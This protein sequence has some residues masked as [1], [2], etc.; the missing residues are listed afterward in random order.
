[1]PPYP[2]KVGDTI[3]TFIERLPVGS[4]PCSTT[5]YR[6]ICEGQEDATSSINDTKYYA[7]IIALTR[8]R[9]LCKDLGRRE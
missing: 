7:I 4:L 6:K 9:S 2:P 3:S 1:M 5:I 8:A